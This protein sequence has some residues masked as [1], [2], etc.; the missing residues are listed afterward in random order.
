M[1]QCRPRDLYQRGSSQHSRPHTVA[2]ERVRSHVERTS[3]KGAAIRSAEDFAGTC[4]ERCRDTKFTA[5]KDPQKTPEDPRRVPGAACSPAKTR[6]KYK[7]TQAQVAGH[8]YRRAALCTASRNFVVLS[9]SERLTIFCV[10]CVSGRRVVKRV[11]VSI[12]MLCSLLLVVLRCPETT[13]QFSVWIHSPQG[14]L[15]NRVRIFVAG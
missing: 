15:W 11:Y 8:G 1:Q 5:Q 14:D 9:L 3:H 2:C 7:S 12:Q 6:T 13:E 4:I 10:W